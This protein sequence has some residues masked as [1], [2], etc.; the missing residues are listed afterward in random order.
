VLFNLVDVL[1]EEFWAYTL[2]TIDGVAIRLNDSSDKLK[3]SLT[4]GHD[5]SCSSLLT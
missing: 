2:D 4:T 1:P 5:S 3:A